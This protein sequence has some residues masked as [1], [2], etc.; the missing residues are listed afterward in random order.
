[1]PSAIPLGHAQETTSPA[2]LRGQV[3]DDAGFPL[4]GVRVQAAA[5]AMGQQLWWVQSNEL[6]TLSGADGRFELDLPFADILYSVS[7]NMPGYSGRQ[8][9]IIGGEQPN[10]DLRLRKVPRQAQ[11]KGRIVDPTGQPLAG[12]D[13]VLLGEYGFSA[14]TVTA[15]DGEFWFDDLPTYYGQGVLVL[16]AAQ[17]E[18]PVQIVRAQ[19]KDLGKLTAVPPAT[20]RGKLTDRQTGAPIAGAKVTIRPRFMSGLR[21]DATTDHE[22]AYEITRVP[23]GQYLVEPSAPTYFDKPPRGFSFERQQYTAAA[24]QAVEVNLTMQPMDQV[25]GAVVDRLGKPVPGALV[26]I[27]STWEGDYRD[28]YRALPTDADGKFQIYTGHVGESLRL[29]AFSPRLGLA[30]L[31]LEPIA[32]GQQRKAITLTLPGA[33]RFKGEIV[34]ADGK[35]I[36]NVGATAQWGYEVS[37]LTNDRGRFDLGWVSLRPD[38]KDHPLKLQPPRP[39]RGYIIGGDPTSG[40]PIPLDGSFFATATQVIAPKPSEL[41]DIRV[42]LEQT[43]L[44]TITGHVVGADGNAVELA[45]IALFAGNAKPDTWINATGASDMGGGRLNV[46]SDRRVASAQTGPD[47]SFK[48]QVVREDGAKT[49]PGTLFSV[50]AAKQV[51]RPNETGTR[52]RV[53]GTVRIMFGKLLTDLVFPDG[54]RQLDVTLKLEEIPPA[55]QPSTGRPR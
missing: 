47:G 19:Q 1:M 2:R 24:G 53:A 13:L 15:I 10:V 25:S 34:D 55:T 28:Q 45:S 20:F 40:V 35:P 11:L 32:Q 49:P 4:A 52:G 43:E 17:V 33:M 14:Q 38:M 21:L 22:G 8:L 31:Q 30:G 23:P 18:L 51:Q 7:A 16:S 6:F 5:P 46:I 27:L 9:R 42:A 48:I 41:I 50:G 37:D 29:E 3:L 26:S 39:Q 36:P 44:L 54:Q 12:A